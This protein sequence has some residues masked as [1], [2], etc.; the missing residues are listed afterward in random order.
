MKILNTILAGSLALSAGCA[1]LKTVDTKDSSFRP[2]SICE[3]VSGDLGADRM[4]AR[5]DAAIMNTMLSGPQYMD[6]ERVCWQTTYQPG[7]QEIES[8]VAR[9]NDWVSDVI[10]AAREAGIS[11]RPPQD[12]YNLGGKTCAVFK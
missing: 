8:C 10:T 2:Y 11:E 4:A 1:A 9:S 5:Q 6:G 7:A 12:V 3:T